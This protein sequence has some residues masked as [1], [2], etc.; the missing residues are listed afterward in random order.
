MRRE[1]QNELLPVKIPNLS[2]SLKAYQVNT[3]IKHVVTKR[4]PEEYIN[5]LKNGIIAYDN[6][7]SS[8]H[9]T[10]ILEP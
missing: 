7:C 2:Y 9:K 1:Q 10:V 8:F 4:T 3:D 5:V 6:C